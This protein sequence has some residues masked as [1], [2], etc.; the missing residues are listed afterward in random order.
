MT[1]AG[2]PELTVGGRTVT[3]AHLDEGA[4]PEIA[5]G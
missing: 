2:G 3:V 5:F 1:P 4:G